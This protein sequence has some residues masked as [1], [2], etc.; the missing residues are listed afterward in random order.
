MIAHDVIVLLAQADA[1]S[2]DAMVEP[3]R[4]A[5][6]LFRYFGPVGIASVVLWV[7]AAVWS[8]WFC[9]RHPRGS[10]AAIGALLTLGVVAFAAATR[11]GDPYAWAF[12]AAVV[13]V[14]IQLIFFAGER[15]LPMKSGLVAIALAAFLLGEWNSSN[16]SAIETD[17]TAVQQELDAKR[18]ERQQMEEAR[19]RRQAAGMPVTAEMSGADKAELEAAGADDEEG[20]YERAA[21]AAVTTEP[22]YRQQGKQRRDPSR[23]DESIDLPPMP[24]EDGGAAEDAA[25]ARLLPQADVARANRWDRLN[26]AL[27]RWAPWAA[28]VLLLVDYLYGMSRTIGTRVP[29]PVS[30]RAIDALFDKSMA[31]WITGDRGVVAPLLTE[32][33]RKG[34]TFIY[35]GPDDP[36]AGRASLPRLGNWLGLGKLTLD[37]DAAAGRAEVVFESAWFNRLC[38]AIACGADSPD[39]LLGALVE[40]L[41]MRRVPKAAA[42]RTVSLVWDLHDPPTA[43]QVDMLGHLCRRANFRLIVRASGEHAVD[44]SRFDELIE[45]PAGQSAPVISRAGCSP[46]GTPSR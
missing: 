18:A 5:A 42:R 13:L 9:I 37:A 8:V 2:V 11:W 28:L 15:R 19:R 25:P 30:H 16:V 36:L 33:V 40:A 10:V 32:I 26:L 31:T 6:R 23:I 39:R 38:I 1:E 46:S 41:S 7:A 17:M 12:A 20:A 21:D 44:L 27:T 45:A 14:V 22:R 35:L 43:A 34:E 24:G 3:L 4:S 29:L